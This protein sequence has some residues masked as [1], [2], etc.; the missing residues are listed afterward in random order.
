MTLLTAC[1]GL[2]PLTPDGLTARNIP[3]CGREPQKLHPARGRKCPTRL[4]GVFALTQGCPRQ[5]P[6]GRIAKNLLT[7]LANC[8]QWILYHR[9]H[10]PHQFTIAQNC[11]PF[12]LRVGGV[13]CLLRPL[14]VRAWRVPERRRNYP[15]L[16]RQRFGVNCPLHRCIWRVQYNTFGVSQNTTLSAVTKKIWRPPPGYIHKS[17][18]YRGFREI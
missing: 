17:A 18:I 13:F 7:Q 16:L 2:R 4:K 15:L 5:G 9:Y 8:V 3:P 10:Q 14:R 12:G 1:R 11:T 6:R